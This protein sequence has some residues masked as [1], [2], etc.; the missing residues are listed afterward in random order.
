MNILWING[1]P[2]PDFARC[3]GL[4]EGGGLW[5]VRLSKAI[6]SSSSCGNKLTI[7]CAVSERHME[8]SVELD[9]I[10]YIGI[11]SKNNSRSYSTDFAES[12][13]N[14]IQQI[15]PDIIHIWGTENEFSYCSFKAAEETGYANRTLV[16]IQ[17]LVSII[18]LHC[19]T[20]IPF[21]YVMSFTLSEMI[22]RRNIYLL[23]KEFSRRGQY[24]QYVLR[25]CH[26]I[27]GRTLWDKAYAL[28]QNPNC[29]YYIS[30]ETLR[31][32][33]YNAKWSVGK[34]KR[35]TIFMSSSSYPVKGLHMMLKALHIIKKRYPDVHLYVPG[36]NRCTERIRDRIRFNS[37]DNYLYK[38][39]SQYDLKENITFLGYLSENEMLAQYLRANVFVSASLIENSSNAIGEAMILGVPVVAS[40]VG[41]IQ[42]LLKHEEEGFLYSVDEPHMLARYVLDIFENDS[43]ALKLSAGGRKRALVTHSLEKNQS[44]LM[45][46][47]NRIV[48]NESDLGISL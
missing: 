6:Q 3:L 7:I 11:Y 44:E 40:C 38:L 43:I 9:G 1:S 47:Y 20:G 46:V 45:S 28:E 29:N 25:H 27:V 18:A 22:R 13:K 42:S 34:C 23:G 41:G 5:L 26:H 4:S 12:V 17:G 16:S 8:K 33:F 2:L 36:K 39:I 32:P 21:R 19:Y 48:E 31:T 15:K 37:Y 14:V 24:E 35:H 30:N 10:K